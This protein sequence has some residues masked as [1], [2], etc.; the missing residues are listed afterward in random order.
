MIIV[1]GILA[2]TRR[3]AGGRA[4]G[5]GQ[6]RPRR[7]RALGARARPGRLRRPA[8]GNVGLRPAQAR[9]AGMARPVAVDLA[10]ARRRRGAVAVPA[11][12][13][14][15]IARGRGA[16]HRPGDPAQP[17]AARRAD[18]VLLPVLPAGRACSS[19]CRCSSPSRSGCPRSKPACGCCRSRSRCCWPP[20]ASRS[21]SRRPRRAG[22]CGSASSRC[23]R[24][25]S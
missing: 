3:M 24:G 17:D 16:A 2:L 7:H 12:E 25:S 15:L 1:L 8:L 22:S 6:P 10:D 4:G 11:W 23:S 5:A 20:P 18:L 13:S 19:R 9:G 21:C 14:R